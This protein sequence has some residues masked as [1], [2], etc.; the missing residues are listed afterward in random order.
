MSRRTTAAGDPARIDGGAATVEAGIERAANL[1]R[2]ARRVLVTGLADATLEAIGSACD[3]AETL[4]AAIDTGDPDAA[5]PLGPLVARAG[6]VSADREELRDRAD[7]VIAWFCDPSASDP[8]FAKALSA[9]PL[10]DSRGRTVLAVGPDRFAAAARHISLPAETAV[11]AARLLNALL[12]GHD[13][14]ADNPAAAAVAAACHELAGAIR[15]A[16]C[17]GVITCRET[18]PLGLADWAARLLVRQIAHERP[19]FAVPLASA[20]PGDLANAA[21]A[22]AILTWRYAAA[23]AIARA[24]RL[25]A[26]FRPAECSA[27][28]IIGRGECD[29]VLAVGRLP[30]EV[31]EAIASRA[32]DL[33]V[34]RIF[35]RDDEPPGC[36]GPCVHLRCG[37]PVGTILRG[38]GREQAIG[39]PAAAN[40][41]GSMA[42]LIDSLHQRL[43]AGGRP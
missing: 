7:L 4:S 26:G 20:A 38:D 22:A 33:A 10:P 29:A 39:N 13:V 30:A 18:D 11:A 19:A 15:E 34:V 21:G 12:L 16:S 25:G 6:G 3:L 9:P 2:R 8:G 27:A 17:V 32:A 5:S 42:A 36:A 1:L 14:P 43:V 31:E 40:A 37:P 24:D 35:D 28:A 23:G 41:A